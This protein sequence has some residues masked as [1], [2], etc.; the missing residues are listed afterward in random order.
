M[1]CLILLTTLVL[2][3]SA[4]GHVQPVDLRC[5]YLHNP[6]GIDATHPRLSWMLDAGPA[7]A[8]GE[9]QTAWRVLVAS[10]RSILAKDSG[11]LW[12]S[13]RV[14]TDQCT[15]VAYAGV[16]LRSGM[17]CFWKVRVWDR[18][19]KPS[20]WS[21]PAHWSMGLLHPSDWKARWIGKDETASAST[22]AGARRTWFPQV[23]AASTAPVDTRW[24]A[25]A[26]ESAR[27][28]SFQA[29]N[30]RWGSARELRPA[31]MA[32]WG[33]MRRSEDR[34]L[35]ARMLRREFT[36]R[37]PVRRATVYYC[38]LGLSELYL[39]GAKVGNAVLSPALSEYDKRAYYVTYDVTRRLKSGRNA[40]GVLLG[41]GRYFAPRQAV[42]TGTR[43]FGYPK[44]LL[45]MHI[46]FADG[47]STDIVSD[48][49]WKLTTDG[50]IRANN[51]YDG[52]EYDARLQ[53]PGWAKPGFNDTGWEPA[54]LV[55]GPAV[56]SA[57]MTPPIRVT[58]TL[59]PKSVRELAPGVFIFDF[60]QNMVGWCRLRVRGPRGTVVTLR[61][62]ETLQPDGSLYVANLR[63]AKATDTYIL[64]GGGLEVYEPRFTYHGFRYVE[65]RGFPGRPTLSALTGCVVHDDLESAGEWRCSNALLN[66]IYANIRWGVRG[67][68]RSIPTD[69][70]Q[71]DERQGWL[72][73]RSA[74][75]KGETYLFNVAP[76][77]TKWLRDMA[78]A[79]RDDGSVPDVC[80]AYWPL[81]SDNVTWP[82]STVIIPGH[83]FTQYGD[84]ELI[85]AHYP[86]MKRW[87]EHMGRYVVGDLLPRDS[88][89]DWCVPPENRAL[90]HSQDPAR[91]TSGPLL[92]TA[93]YYHC[94]KL[95]A[96]YASLL[97]KTDDAAR[98]TQQAARTKAAFNG[99]FLKPD[100]S[101][102]D[103]GSQ[104]SCIVPL[105]FGLVPP[106]DR[107]RIFQHL[108]GSITGE[109]HN[110]IGT[111]LIGGQFLMQTLTK[112]GRADL[113][114]VL[115][116]NTT[117]PSW[118]Y[119]VSKG[120][121]TIWELWNGDTAD[122]AMNS[123]NH[124]MLVGDLLTWLFEDL[125][126]I[127][128]DPAHPGFKHIIMHPRAPG[129]LRFVRAT[130][131]SPYGLILS[132]WRRSNGVFEWKV[133]I[134]PNATATLCLP[135]ENPACVTESG[136]P[137]VNAPGVRFR[138][139]ADGCVVCEV[140][141]GHYSF[142]VH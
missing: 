28:A 42:P 84:K 125:A 121:T 98:F 123:G 65:V 13:G 4:Q 88:Y 25:A 87:L 115:A 141:S 62:A 102:Y 77:Y 94:L 108:I 81:Y 118:G 5:E 46:E 106:Q 2:A 1:T 43:S 38:G 69:C 22:F 55:A 58:A 103:N 124:V 73:D 41:N 18:R 32:S 31:G 60:G 100:G 68:Y 126:G 54:Q 137:L 114:Y 51:E 35:P 95:M 6:Q 96:W 134:P 3:G 19:G 119:M 34:R 76:F 48:G 105:A 67:N 112:G 53:M 101:Q 47:S 74:E 133:I 83:M 27:W 64:K 130:H 59:K 107:D 21:V 128:A 16:P 80:P 23:H 17:E 20:A 56:L 111:G 91:R 61:H 26:A 40:V 15:N 97:G 78:D 52:E 50:P 36:I 29:N 11:D 75:S 63:S 49:A 10:S 131:R 7:P 129:D 39:N 82:S 8:R 142:R 71:R 90:I 85:A 66:R 136:R 117:Y 104:T 93:Y 57:Q 79:Q 135:A 89:G 132:A 12:D 122:P 120:A 86:S 44:L 110:H 70:P 113:A 9:R 72:G 140:Q 24:R 30:A 139:R 99:A 109:F 14:S 33:G 116:T 127:Q 92:G 138:G 37:R 45:Q